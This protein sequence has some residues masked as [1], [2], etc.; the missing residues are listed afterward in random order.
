VYVDWLL[1]A[2]K[3]VTVVDKRYLYYTDY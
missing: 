2:Q 3:E 1:K